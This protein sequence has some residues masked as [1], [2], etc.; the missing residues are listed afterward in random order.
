MT[1]PTNEEKTCETCKYE[2][3][4][5]DAC[6]PTC[7]DFSDHTPKQP[8]PIEPWAGVACPQCDHEDLFKYP[9]NLG[10]AT[11]KTCGFSASEE[12]IEHY[13]TLQGDK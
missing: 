12:F 6:Y 5:E 11:C 10:F 2:D 8:T 4:C 1:K 9:R 13:H 3:M 7:I